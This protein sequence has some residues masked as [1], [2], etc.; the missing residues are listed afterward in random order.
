MQVYNVTK[1]Q[2]LFDVAL[3]CHGSIEGV[4]DLLINNDEL[5]FES[6]L[7]E[8]DELY[9]DEDFV[10]NSTIVDTLSGDLNIVPANGERHVYYKHITEP[11]ACIITVS[12]EDPSIMLKMAGDGVITVDWGDNT[13]LEAITLQPTMKTYQHF[14]DNEVEQRTVRLYGSFNLKTWDLSSIN[15]LFLPVKPIVVDEVTASKNKLSMQ[16]LFLFSGTYSVT[17]TGLSLSSL[18]M[19]RDMSLSEL[20]LTGNEY[21]TDD[22]LN[23]YLIYVAKHNNERR[24]CKVT[25][26]VQPSGEYKE[27]SKDSSGNYVIETGMEAIYVITH[28]DAWNEAGAWVFDINGTIYQYE[29]PDIA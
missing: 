10:I 16:G 17:L 9:W 7:K 11:L 20:V 15:G 26:D 24:N 2:N 28:E 23:D 6:K 4:F 21:V 8:G 25:L 22:V 12:E 19:I 18:D 14:F 3:S 13:E 5:S 29:N 1:G 27:P